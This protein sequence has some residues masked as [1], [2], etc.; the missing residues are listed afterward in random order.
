MQ[1][2]FSFKWLK[3]TIWL[4]LL[5]ANLKC[6]LALPFV[7][8]SVGQSSPKVVC[9]HQST[10]RTEK[11]KDGISSQTLR[12]DR[13]RGS[14]FSVR[15]HSPPRPSKA[16]SAHT[17]LFCPPPPCLTPSC[18]PPAPFY[19]LCWAYLLCGPLPVCRKALAF[20]PIH[21][22]PALLQSALWHFCGRIHHIPLT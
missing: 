14:G 19:P 4:E 10:W 8:V 22:L 2:R 18:P 21:W 17:V 15:H 13:G 20:P 16:R 5:R 12:P 11:T 7:A 9:F 6:F 3:S 1:T